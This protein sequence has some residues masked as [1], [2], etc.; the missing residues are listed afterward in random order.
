MNKIKYSTVA[1]NPS[2]SV[3]RVFT[4]SFGTFTG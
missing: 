1:M 2:R 3:V 4:I